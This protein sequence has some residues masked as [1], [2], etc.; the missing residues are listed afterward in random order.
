MPKIPY[1]KRADGRY[2]KQIIIGRDENGKNKVKT[3]YDRDWKKLDRKV[4]EF[5][6]GLRQGVYIKND[7]TFGECVKLW[8]NSKVD[9]VEGTKRGYQTCANYFLSLYNIKMK[10]IKPIHLQN[11][12]NDMT[13]RGLT[14]M[15][16]EVK[17]IFLHQL[18]TFA[19]NNN[20]ADTDLSKKLTV[21]KNS[22]SDK[23]RALYEWEKEGV[24]KFLKEPTSS[25]KI[26]KYK[27]MV[28]LLYFTGIRAGE[29]LSLK[30]DRDI[31]MDN[32]TISIN[33]TTIRGKDYRTE[34]KQGTKTQSVRGIRIIPMPFMLKEI[35]TEYIEKHN[36]TS[37]LFLSC[38]GSFMNSCDLYK[39]WSFIRK[40]IS[41]YIPDCPQLEFTPH[42]LR[43]NYATEL[44]YA[45]VPI[46]T[47]QYLMG[48]KS[49]KMT[50][51]IYTDVKKDDVKINE[52]VKSVWR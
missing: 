52:M 35:L 45:N 36:I 51:D 1:S 16:K 27:A 18:Y 23:R 37:Y 14:A 3:L 29:M 28:A 2:Y 49:I 17:T 7:I 21:K 32:D 6:V 40:T 19:I 48:H 42:Y 13:E 26:L 22:S 5:K 12:I 11:I 47:V 31:S 43:H 50:M 4:Q 24:L 9:I 20:F 46:K 15:Q 8:M 30:L 44:I 25:L 38:H 34:E 41:K 10:D 39:R 33:H